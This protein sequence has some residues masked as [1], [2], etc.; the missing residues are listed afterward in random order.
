MVII[1]RTLSIF[2]NQSLSCKNPV[3]ITPPDTHEVHL[4][5]EKH[6]HCNRSPPRCQNIEGWKA[7]SCDYIL[8]EMLIKE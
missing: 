8:P 3:T 2:K 1:T 6:Q 7:A 5:E 4:G